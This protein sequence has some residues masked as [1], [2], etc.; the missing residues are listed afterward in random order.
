MKDVLDRNKPTIL[1]SSCLMGDAVRW[2]STGAS[3]KWL[4][5]SLS[6]HVNIQKVCPE[7]MMGLGVPRKTIR[8]VHSGT[9]EIRVVESKGSGEHTKSAFDTIPEVVKHGKSV[10]GFILKS[11]SPSC[12]LERVKVYNTKTGHPDKSSVGL[13]AKAL[14]EEYSDCAFIDEGRLNDYRLREHFVTHLFALHRLKTIE[15]KISAL[16]EFHAKNKYLIMCYKHSRVSELGR[17]CSKGGKEDFSKLY[18]EYFELFSR[19]LSEPAPQGQIYSTLQHIY[20]YF[21]K[22]LDPKEKKHILNVVDDYK[23]GRVP[24]TIPLEILRFLTTKYDMSYLSD[25]C[26]F[27]PYPESL[28]LRRFI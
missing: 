9:D 3:C 6:K 28:S 15:P 20:G 4:V 7:M 8:L 2:N 10:D 11:K 25:Q 16:Q 22:V 23:R 1:V 26:L 21:K 27:D 14:R 17:I 13:F 18:L 24:M 19:T 12:G 5:H